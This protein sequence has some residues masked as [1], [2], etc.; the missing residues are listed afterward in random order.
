[1]IYRHTTV[2]A[3]AEEM[4]RRG[5]CE[6]AERAG[7]DATRSPEFQ[8]IPF[9]RHFI[10]GAAQCVSLIFI[11]SFFALQWLAPYL[12]YD[13]VSGEECCFIEAILGA[14]VS[15]LVLYPLMLAILIVLKWIVIGR[16]RPGAH[17]LWGTYYFRWWLVTTIE[18]AVPVGYMTGTPLLN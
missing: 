2:E 3:L 12:N 5:K 16:Y 1:D 8:P 17:P 15:L 9:W 10:C 13:V 14:F 18:A 4:Q 6:P 11:L 7:S